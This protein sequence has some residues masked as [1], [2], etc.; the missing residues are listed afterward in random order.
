MRYFA[1]KNLDWCRDQKF[2]QNEHKSHF[3]HTHL[4]WATLWKSSFFWQVFLPW[5]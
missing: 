3:S 4:S 2:S 1:L 5:F